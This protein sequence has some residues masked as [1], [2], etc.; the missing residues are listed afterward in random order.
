[1]ES[2]IKNMRLIVLGMT[3]LFSCI[4]FTYV[5]LKTQY[6]TQ[7][8]ML[9]IVLAYLMLYIVLAYLMLYIVLAYLML[10]I[11]LAYLMLFA[12]LSNAV[13]IMPLF[14]QLFLQMLFIFMLCLGLLTHSLFI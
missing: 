12:A 10:Y 5:D 8:L 7:Y 11:V 4:L 13:C 1:M 9:Y 6:S 14:C 3:E 2:S